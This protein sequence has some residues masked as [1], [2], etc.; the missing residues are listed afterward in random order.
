MGLVPDIPCVW[1]DPATGERTSGFGPGKWAPCEEEEFYREFVKAMEKRS[2]GDGDGDGEM[3]TRS[4]SQITAD[5]TVLALEYKFVPPTWMIFIVRAV[6]TH[7]RRE[8]NPRVR[9]RETESVV[10]SDGWLV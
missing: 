9:F 10:C 2:G 6:I 3:T 4:F 7:A 8:P 1:I 5:L